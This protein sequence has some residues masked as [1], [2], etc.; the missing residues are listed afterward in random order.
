MHGNALDD[1]GIVHQ[2]V[3]LAH[4]GMNLVYQFLHGVLVGHVA[5]VALHVGNS[6]LLVVVKSALQSLFVAVVEDDGLNTSGHKCLCNVEADS[7]RSTG[8]PGVLTL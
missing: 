8:N 7:V 2:N 3:N 5:D 1:A 6:S 4:L